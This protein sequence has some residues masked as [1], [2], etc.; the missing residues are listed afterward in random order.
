MP[1]ELKHYG[2]KSARKARASGPVSSVVLVQREDGERGHCFV[3][4]SPT[5]VQAVGKA[6]TRGVAD[7]DPAYI[8][9]L[10]CHKRK[11]WAVWARYLNDHSG[12]ALWHTPTVPSWLRFI[13]STPKAI[14]ASTDS[15]TTGRTD[16]ARSPGT[17]RDFGEAARYA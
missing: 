14:N 5:F 7:F 1:R 2:L 6:L 10:Y 12:S 3:A 11:A 15:Q 4:F 16:H 13:P 17:V 8:E 9:V